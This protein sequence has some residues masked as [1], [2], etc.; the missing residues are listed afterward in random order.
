VKLRLPFRFSHTRISAQ[1]IFRL[2]ARRSLGE[3]SCRRLALKASKA[4][5]RP[6]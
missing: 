3:S 4:R 5:K 2:K 1:E 6:G